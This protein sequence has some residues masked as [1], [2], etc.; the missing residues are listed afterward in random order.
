MHDIDKVQQKI[1]ELCTEAR[2]F[3]K[4]FSEYEFSENE[5]EL[6]KAIAQLEAIG[7]IDKYDNIQIEMTRG[8]CKVIESGDIVD[9]ELNGQ[10]SAQ[11]RLFSGMSEWSDDRIKMETVCH[12]IL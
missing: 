10:K 8:L 7:M 3:K 6:I 5:F 12:N 2:E 11:I 4:I 9:L 1:R